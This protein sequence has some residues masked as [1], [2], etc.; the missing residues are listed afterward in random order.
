[1]SRLTKEEIKPPQIV[2]G[3]LLIVV[4]PSLVHFIIYTN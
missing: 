3:G 2:V 1:M 4:E